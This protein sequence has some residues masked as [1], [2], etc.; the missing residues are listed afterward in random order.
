[1]YT[2]PSTICGSASGTYSQLG[3]YG[4]TACFVFILH[5]PFTIFAL[6]PALKH[7]LP[8]QQTACFILCK[9]YSI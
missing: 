3:K 4:F 7:K 6:L 1:M 2:R 9:Y 5:P 8:N